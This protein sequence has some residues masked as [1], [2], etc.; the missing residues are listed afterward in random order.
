MKIQYSV[1]SQNNTVTNKD[2]EILVS[3]Q[4]A[5]VSTSF[6]SVALMRGLGGLFVTFIQTEKA[7]KTL[8]TKG[9]K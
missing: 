5:G 7:V 2:D 3:F 4:S 6:D 9:D 8:I 1:A